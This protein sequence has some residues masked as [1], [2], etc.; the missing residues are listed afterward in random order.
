M[1]YGWTSKAWGRVMKEGSDGGHDERRRGWVE[2]DSR[3]VCYRGR[4]GS[5]Y[6]ADVGSATALRVGDWGATFQKYS[7]SYTIV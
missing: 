5:A 6:Q 3:D 4:L 2:G 7:K 1:A